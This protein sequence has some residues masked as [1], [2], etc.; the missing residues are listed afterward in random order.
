MCVCVC[1][2][3]L[4]RTVVALPP[5]TSIQNNLWIILISMLISD[6]TYAPCSV[7]AD[8]AVVNSLSDSTKYGQVRMWGTAGWGITA[9]GG[10]YMISR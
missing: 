8:A 7:L 6:A 2:G 9:L 5:V 1:A 3:V 4:S 10:G